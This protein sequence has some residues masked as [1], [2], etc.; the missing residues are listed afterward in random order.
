MTLFFFFL[1]SCYCFGSLCRV[2]LP[3]SPLFAVSLPFL[4]AIDRPARRPVREPLALDGFERQCAGPPV[5][6]SLDVFYWEY[7]QRCQS[8]GAVDDD[9][10]ILLA[11][12]RA[13]G[14]AAR[15]PKTHVAYK[16]CL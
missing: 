10:A 8:A 12:E 14:T 9:F 5:G 2:V 7:A 15:E 13:I 16:C 4:V 3:L 11:D 1:R 6:Q